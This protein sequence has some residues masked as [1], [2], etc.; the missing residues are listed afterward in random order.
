MALKVIKLQSRFLLLPD[1]Y[2][3]IYISFY[4]TSIYLKVR[5]TIALVVL[6]SAACM[7]DG[8][9]FVKDLNGMRWTLDVKPT[10]TIESLKQMI[11]AKKGI[12]PHQ[13]ELI[14]ASKWLRD[15]CYSNSY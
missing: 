4:T 6:I 14:F 7:G 10:D 8:P 15:L 11:Q 13:M 2:V 12:S 9:I 1:L 3:Y 5:L